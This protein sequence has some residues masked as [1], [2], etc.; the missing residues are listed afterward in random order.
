MTDVLL[1][2]EQA[3]E[4]GKLSISRNRSIHA[5]IGTSYTWLTHHKWVVELF[6]EIESALGILVEDVVVHFNISN[7]NSRKKKQH[8][9]IS[10]IVVIATEIKIRVILSFVV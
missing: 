6:S 5:D 10:A 7:C 1:A 3:V 9:L 8:I 2:I 4:D